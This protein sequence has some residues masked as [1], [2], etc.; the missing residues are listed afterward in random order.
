MLI[1]LGQ[2]SPLKKDAGVKCVD[3]TSFFY[4]EERE[5]EREIEFTIRGVKSLIGLFCHFQT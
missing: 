3:L 2:I 1:L 4:K 5:R